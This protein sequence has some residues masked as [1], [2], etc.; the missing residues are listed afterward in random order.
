MSTYRGVG[1][2]VRKSQITSSFF[3]YKLLNL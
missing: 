3:G 1:V 2:E